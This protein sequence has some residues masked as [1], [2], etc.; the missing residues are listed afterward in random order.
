[1]N[2]QKLSDKE[3]KHRLRAHEL[4]MGNL[5]LDGLEPSKE[6]IEDGLLYAHG[7]ISREEQLARL[8][9]R[10]KKVMEGS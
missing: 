3:I 5:R 9:A 8:K 2:K 7:E 6:Q 4:A 10:L 1:M